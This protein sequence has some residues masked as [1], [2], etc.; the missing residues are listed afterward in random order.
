M[1]AR[2]DASVHAA[3]P[4]D[5]NGA[6]PVAT[7][8]RSAAGRRSRL[9]RYLLG[10]ILVVLVTLLRMPL[11]P[12]IGNSVPFNLYFP[13]ILIAGWFGGFG[14]GFVATLFA[15]VCA[16]TWFF[17]PFGSFSIPDWGSAFRLIVFI[18]NGTLASFLCGLLHNRTE[19]LQKEKARL[20]ITVQDR[21][22]HLQGALSDMEA[23]SYTVSH[24]LRSP[25]RSMHGFSEILLEKYSDVL[26]SEGQGYLQRI[27]KAAGR[28]DHLINDL[29]A[30]AKVSGTAIELKPLPLRD[31][32]ARVVDSSARWTST[33][34]SLSYD[35]CVHTV[36]ANETMLNQILQNLM[37]NAAKYVA[38]GVKP[39]I[40]VW[41]EERGE[42][43]RVWV[44]DNGIGIAPEN[45]ARLFQL[46]E[47]L[48][49]KRYSGTGIGLAIVDRAALK[50][51]GRVGVESQPG[52]G[53][54]FWVELARG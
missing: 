48:D 45:Q 44:A 50:M 1:R 10:V 46:F 34:V 29:L 24:D 25:M 20:E 49:H 36:M 19:E 5:H 40:R 6:P 43:I 31:A 15:G 3:P 28:L 42:I 22:T 11:A 14:P 12:L 18:V 39:E 16:K 4:G 21:T 8:T 26:D 27:R 41:S 33:E 53:S 38:P 30:F 47:R 32:V 23:F 13:A 54:R 7:E 35:G 9:L 37:E 51:R 52:S 2:N 17:E